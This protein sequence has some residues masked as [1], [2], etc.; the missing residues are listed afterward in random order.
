MRTLQEVINKRELVIQ[1]LTEKQNRDI[2]L[3]LGRNTSTDVSIITPNRIMKIVFSVLNV[4]AL[5]VFKI[6]RATGKVNRIR[7]NVQARF[8]YFYFC[9][10]YGN[11]STSL[12]NI[13]KVKLNDKVVVNYDHSS[14]IHAV[15]SWRDWCE[16][17]KG[18]KEKND[19]IDATLQS[20]FS[21]I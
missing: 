11:S 5:E 7:K 14:I 20:L 17:D 12:K 1:K 13:G 10:K 9:R 21:V 6:H 8:A 19:R 2:D 4:D 15:K 3:L 18:I 16:V